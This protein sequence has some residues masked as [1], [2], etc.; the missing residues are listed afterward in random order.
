[1]ANERGGLV[2]D[3]QISFKT[4]AEAYRVLESGIRVTTYTKT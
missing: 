3:Y 2:L 4:G 1:M